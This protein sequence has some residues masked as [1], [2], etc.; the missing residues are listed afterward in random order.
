LPVGWAGAGSAG[1]AEAGALEPLEP[2]QLERIQRALEQLAQEYQ[3]QRKPEQ[4]EP[5]Q[6]EQLKPGDRTLL[7]LLQEQNDRRSAQTSRRGKSRG[8]RRSIPEGDP[9]RLIVRV[10]VTLVILGLSAFGIVTG[11]DTGGAW[12]AIGLVAGYWLRLSGSSRLPP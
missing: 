2:E 7:E 3:E 8:G 12:G 4:P 9:V 10:G 1:A 11:T 5:E 6:P